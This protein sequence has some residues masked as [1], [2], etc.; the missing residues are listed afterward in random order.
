MHQFLSGP[1]YYLN[2]TNSGGIFLTEKDNGKVEDIRKLLITAENGTQLKTQIL[3]YLNWV[4]SD[5]A[6][7]SI[8]KS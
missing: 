1:S 2:F 3:R 6:V 8:I 5:N 7:Y 4:S